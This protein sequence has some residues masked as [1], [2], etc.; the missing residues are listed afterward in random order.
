VNSWHI[1][2][3]EYPPDIG[4]V[5]EYTRQ[6]AEALVAAGDEVHV[7]CP[8]RVS[9][10][11][12]TSVHVHGEMGAIR[13]SDLRR[14]DRRLRAH[15]PP[16]RLLV[17]WVPHGFGY[18]SM[19]VWFCLWIA[20]RA[21]RGD[22]V[23]LVVHEPF[24][25][26]SG[27]LRHRA[28]AVVHRLMTIVLLAASRHVWMSIPAWESRLRPYALG[29]RLSMAWLPVP[30]A[31]HSDTTAA[32]ARQRR[33]ESNDS[34]PLIGHFGSY[35]RDVSALLEERLT[36]IMEHESTPSVLLVGAGSETFRQTLLGRHA[37]W[38][39]RVH[40]TGFVEPA[41]LS[42][43]LGLCDLFIQPYP[44]GISSRRT[45][46]MSCL[47]LGRAVV[48]TRGHLTEPLWSDSGAV[49][50]ADVADVRS[51]TG[52]VA[53]LLTN[54]VER[55]RLGVAAQRLYEDRFSV[56]RLVSALRVA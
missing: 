33:K 38:A 51:F 41:G 53:R 30:G 35:G 10:T 18:R 20:T 1:V 48:T 21:W 26:F 5:S 11:A 42:A 24:V 29:R 25:E 37:A 13:P 3:S 56:E 45:S 22:H 46:A 47:A 15:Q 34:R 36:A 43:A 31:A 39:S 6:V 28:M 14:L 32:A 19:N 4:G 9:E 49:A 7:W 2:T 55:Q 52:A 40:A 50:L 54:T 17:Q 16:R 27:S 12:S 44:D 23:Q 8:N